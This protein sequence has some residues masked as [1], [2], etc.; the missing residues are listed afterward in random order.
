MKTLSENGTVFIARSLKPLINLCQMHN[1]FLEIKEYPQ[2]FVL[3]VCQFILEALVW[4]SL[5]ISDD[6]NLVRDFVLIY[7]AFLSIV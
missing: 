2:I 1:F 3:F 4:F 7:F 5:F 6:I